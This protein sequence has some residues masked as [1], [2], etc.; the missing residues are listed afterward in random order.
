MRYFHI[1]VQHPN[2]RQRPVDSLFEQRNCNCFL[3]ANYKLSSK[4]GWKQKYKAR[5]IRARQLQISWWN[6]LHKICIVSAI[7]LHPLRPLVRHMEMLRLINIISNWSRAERSGIVCDRPSN[8]VALPSGWQEM[9]EWWMF[10]VRCSKCSHRQHINCHESSGRM[11]CERVVCIFYRK[12]KKVHGAAH[13]LD[14]F[15]V[16]SE[17]DVSTISDLIQS[18][19]GTLFTLHNEYAFSY[20]ATAIS[21]FR[22]CSFSLLWLLCAQCPRDAATRA[23]SNW[24]AN[25]QCSFEKSFSESYYYYYGIRRS[26]QQFRMRVMSSLIHTSHQLKIQ[27]ALDPTEIFRAVNWIVIGVAIRSLARCN[28]FWRTMASSW[29]Q[30]DFCCPLKRHA[31]HC[32]HQSRSERVRL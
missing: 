15:C 21:K 20:I 23:Q 2:A 31:V 18:P 16:A 27:C 26:S 1:L 14:A 4:F 8:A 32:E 17:T 5:F 13:N 28:R 10:N 25:V 9:G 11:R 7:C 12:I 6:W 30:V 29:K 24:D 22:F 19:S 3:G